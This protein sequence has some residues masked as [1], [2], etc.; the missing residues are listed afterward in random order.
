MMTSATAA[1]AKLHILLARPIYL[2][3]LS[4]ALFL[5]D[6]ERVLEPSK[7]GTY[8]R[9]PYREL[10]GYS[11]L[12][13]QLLSGTIPVTWHRFHVFPRGVISQDH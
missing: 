11:T 4:M 9:Y 5:E 10:H 2:P 12:I 7:T 13:V 1:T 8:A 6:V 3:A